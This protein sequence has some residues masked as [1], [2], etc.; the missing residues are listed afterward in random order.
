MMFLDKVNNCRIQSGRGI[1]NDI[2]I[3][4][5]EHSNRHMLYCQSA[6]LAQNHG[7]KDESRPKTKAQRT[8]QAPKDK[9]QTKNI[10]ETTKETKRTK[11]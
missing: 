8:N 6:H 5:Y 1:D 10:N 3:R 7:F 2:D 11:K 4:S 9:N